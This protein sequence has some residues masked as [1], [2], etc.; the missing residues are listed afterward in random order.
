MDIA[1]CLSPSCPSRAR[2]ERHA[3]SGTRPNPYRQT[4]GGFGPE[5][6]ENR[7]EYFVPA[8]EVKNDARSY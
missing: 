7:C 5:P 8:R 2:C 1:M 6:G 4:Y 3:D